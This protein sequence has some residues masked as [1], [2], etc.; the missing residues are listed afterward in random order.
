M[1]KRKERNNPGWLRPPSATR[2]KNK[3]EL[4]ELVR[5]GKIVDKGKARDLSLRPCLVNAVKGDHEAAWLL[6]AMFVWDVKANDYPGVLKHWRVLEF[7]ASR[8]DKLL[9]QGGDPFK[10]LGLNKKRGGAKS[11][12]S[13]GFVAAV[14]LNELIQNGKKSTAAVK[15]KLHYKHNVSVRE[16]ERAYTKHFRTDKKT[17]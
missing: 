9:H 8:I 16:I 17:R 2:G 13:A 4:R 10:A 6:Y 7:V 1:G 14:E 15:D 5:L 11:I 3:T 12:F